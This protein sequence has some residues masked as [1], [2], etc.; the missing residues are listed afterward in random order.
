[1]SDTG[2]GGGVA[3]LNLPLHVESHGAG[4][5][6]LFLHG[7][8]ANSFTWRRW[9]AAL[10]PRHEVVLVDLKG[11]GAAPKPADGRYSPML[12][13]ELVH[14]L[15]LQRDLRDLTLVGHSLGGGVAL[16]TALRL[17]DSGQAERLSRLVLIG[18]IAYEQP[19]PRYIRWARIPLVGEILLGL[20][21]AERIVRGVLSYIMYDTSA[22]NR[23]MIDGY[24]NPLRGTAAKR[25]LLETARD[26][27]PRDVDE[28]TARYPEI[29]VP[30]LL[31][32]GRQDPITPL[33]VGERLARDL[34]D[35]RLVI[36]EGCG[37]VPPEEKPEECLE[38][39][40]GFLG[41][42]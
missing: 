27:I 37:H 23:G 9:V 24:A 26:L 3:A 5:P 33:W 29:G 1:M 34:P 7:F 6:L 35:A 15:V 20:L 21:S 41:G 12:Q 38:A 4:P 36:L 32:W 18:S 42:A 14:R 40:R 19:L 30:T 22:V 28:I 13:A 16:L 31:L 2:P 10:A 25:A 11:F 39:I 8:G 17:I